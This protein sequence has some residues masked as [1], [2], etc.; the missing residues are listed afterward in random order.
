MRVTCVAA[1]ETTA[2]SS[3][4]LNWTAELQREFDR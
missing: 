1:K 4:C 2:T 3:A